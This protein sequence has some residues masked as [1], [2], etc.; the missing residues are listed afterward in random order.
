VV[1]ARRKDVEAHLFDLLRD[2]EDVL[3]ALV[4]R[5]RPPSGGVRRD[6]TDGENT[7]LHF[8]PL[9]FQCICMDVG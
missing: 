9:S 2:R 8:G 7:E 4:F 1:L 5:G 3:D 6:V